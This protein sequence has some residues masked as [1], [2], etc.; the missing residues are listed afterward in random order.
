M[1]AMSKRACGACSLCCKLP[2]VPELRKPIDTWCKH[3][4]PGCGG[5]SIYPKRPRS[6]RDYICGWLS[7]EPG[8]GDEWFPA[9]CHMMLTPR[10]IGMRVTVDPD[11]PDAWLREPYYKQV[12]QWAQQKP[13]E[14]RIGWRWLWLNPDLPESEMPKIQKWLEGGRA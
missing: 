4:A 7:S 13:V 8:V 2:Y 5:C 6:C 11:Y 14:I 1:N 10:R 3:A 12:R 9:Q